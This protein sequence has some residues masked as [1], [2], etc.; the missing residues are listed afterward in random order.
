MAARRARPIRQVGVVRFLAL[1]EEIQTDI[2]VCMKQRLERIYNIDDGEAIWTDDLRALLDSMNP[3]LPILMVQT[4]LLVQ[5]GRELHDDVV[6]EYKAIWESGQAQFPPV[7]IDSESEEVLCEGGHRSFSAHQAG[8]KEIEAVDVAALDVEAISKKLPHPYKIDFGPEAEREYVDLQKN[9]QNRIDE[10]IARLR[11]WPEVSGVVALWGP[12][13]GHFR[14]KTQDWRVIFHV[15][16]PSHMVI[17][18][19]IANRKEA[20][21]DFHPTSH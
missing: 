5:A 2:A 3:E 8:I 6:A 1:P 9:V 15:D 11:H 17:I 18:D 21:D 12:A 10:L 19:K 7:V 4:W 20:Y 14:M 13:K 16:E